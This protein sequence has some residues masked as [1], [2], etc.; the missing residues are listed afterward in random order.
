MPLWNDLGRTLARDLNYAYINP[1]DAISAYAHEFSRT[2]L[3]ERLSE[4]LY[5][6]DARPGDTHRAFCTV[7][8]DIICTTNFDSL[9]ERQY[10]AIPTSYTSIM[11]EDQLSLNLPHSRTAILKLHGDLNRPNRL[12]VTEEDYDTF[13]SH[14]PLVATYLASLLITRTAVFIGYSLDDPDFRQICQI[15]GQRL[16]KMRRPAYVLCVGARSADI[17]RFDRRGVKAINLAADQSRYGDTLSGTFDELRRYMQ[18]N[19]VARSRVIEVEPLRELSLPVDSATRLCFFALPLAAHPF[20][21]ERVFPLVEDVGLVPVTADEL[22]SEGENIVAKI[23]TLIARASLVV[24]DISSDFT[25]AEA[26]LAFS[27]KAKDK[28]RI[29][30]EGGTSIPSGID[31]SQALFRPDFLAAEFDSFLDRIVAWLRSAAEDLEPT[32]SGEMRRLLEAGENRAA[33]TSAITY[34]ETTLREQVFMPPTKSRGLMSMNRMLELAKET[35]SLGK[36]EVGEIRRW[37]HVRNE[38]VHSHKRVPSGL[39]RQIVLGVEEI[40]GL[41]RRSV[42]GS[43]GGK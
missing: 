35:G 23:D 29:V 36:Y 19:I 41:L 17:A 6:S 18:E 8:F 26:R 25:L 42:S 15:V 5:V 27:R 39:A 40:V 13:L 31:S 28:I 12:I 9:L 7:P 22:V 2:K 1:L 21:R 34:L 14:Y 24:V 11:D 3:I 20:Y 33:V 16:G 32:L 30:I 37:L 4:L 38:A 43:S 10:A